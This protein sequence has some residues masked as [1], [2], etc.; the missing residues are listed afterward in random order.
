MIGPDNARSQPTLA[1]NSAFGRRQAAKVLDVAIQP[2]TRKKRLDLAIDVSG[3]LNAGTVDVTAR[4]L[5]ETGKEEKQFTAQASCLAADRQTLNVS[6]PWADPR[7]WDLDK[8]NLYT[9]ALTVKAPGL[10]AEFKDTFGFREF[11]TQGKQFFLNGLPIRL[12]PT[13][14]SDIDAQRLAGYNMTVITPSRQGDLGDGGP[15]ADWLEK[16]D[17][18]GW[19]TTA[20]LAD[21]AP[22][23]VDRTG[24]VIWN[25]ARRLAWTQRVEAEVRRLKNHPSIVLWTHSPN[26]FSTPQD[27]NPRAIGRVDKSRR[28]TPS[29]LAEVGFEACAIV[30]RLDPTRPVTTHGGADI[31]DVY[32]VNQYLNLIPLQERED[33]LTEWAA[34]GDLPLMAVEF[35]TPLFTTFL[36]GRSQY[37]RAVATEPLLTEFASIY[38]GHQAYIDET[39]DY[40]NSYVG[41]FDNGQTYRFNADRDLA[42][43]VDT[44]AFQKV[45]ALFNRNTWRSWRTTGMAGGMVPLAQRGSSVKAASESGRALAESNG[46]TLACITGPWDAPTAKTHSYHVDETVEKRVVLINDTRRPQQFQYTWR[47]LINGKPLINESGKGQIPPG[48][49]L[50]RPLRFATPFF[51]SGTAEGLIVLTATIG[52]HTHEDRFLYRVFARR[53]R[54]D[55]PPSLPMVDPTGKTG[56]IMPVVDYVPRAWKGEQNVPLVLIGQNALSV[57]RGLPANVETYVRGGGRVLIFEQKP[58]WIEKTLGMRTA[59]YQSRRVFPVSEALTLMRGLD[60]L[61][62]R[63]W[64]GLSNVLPSKPTYTGNAPETGWH[65]GN[66]GVVSSVSIEKPHMSSWTPMLE[67]EFDLAY[68]PLMEMDYGKGRVT[69]CSLDL[70]DHAA[71]DAAAERVFVRLLDIALH[72]PLTPKAERVVYVGGKQGAQFLS[73]LGVIFRDAGTNRPEVALLAGADAPQLLI[74]GEDAAIQP[75]DLAAYLSRGGRAFFLRRGEGAPGFAPKQAILRRHGSLDV[76]TWPECRGL[77][78]S[79]LHWRADIDVPVIQS[80]PDLPA[81]GIPGV[82]TIGA[83]GLLGRIKL[84]PG[85]ALFC[86]IAP[87]R[88]NADTNTYLRLTRWRQTRT[89]CQLLS[90]LGA[91]FQQDARIFQPSP[92]AAPGP[93]FYHPDYRTD[94]ELGDNPYRYFRW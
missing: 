72:S 21:M 93:G 66:R 61:D 14:G 25:E 18:G 5:D 73:G 48:Q 86:Q 24:R 11:W 22:Y 15:D 74:V 53:S 12:R 32:T 37:E 28:T 70:E 54:R 63:D 40:R 20:P 9:I 75:A 80:I 88:L 58:E 52:T 87:D 29:G 44:P 62:L 1:A 91:S 41:R 77:S 26:V 89:V 81:V 57:G 45:E 46:P 7:L 27:Q 13:G 47:A 19:L 78:V 67:D 43:I 60:S 71:T 30:R 16:A 35:G 42:P 76:P 34:N 33:W 59:A 10:D 64:R 36:R 83:D 84:G 51:S 55:R 65:W 3:R 82:A 39:S 56:D 94:L 85:V 23:A 31:G 79:D 38:L 4:L 50:F 17:R 49:T 69:W 8:P 2:S 92:T 68:S 6:F 90:N